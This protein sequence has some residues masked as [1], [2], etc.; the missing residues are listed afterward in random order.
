[1]NRS[2]I[3]RLMASV[4]ATIDA[5][6]RSR[7][8]GYADTAGRCE[9]RIRRLRE[10]LESALQGGDGGPPSLGDSEPSAIL[11]I[12]CELDS[13]ERLQPR[14]DTWLRDHVMALVT[15]HTTEVYDDGA[16]T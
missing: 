4:P 13:L 12:A 11:T 7:L 3:D 1:M 2:Q 16:P 8:T 9:A 5:R 10:E 14:L 6:Q 15:A